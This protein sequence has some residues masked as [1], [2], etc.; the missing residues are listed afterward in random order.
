MG[1]WEGPRESA[2]VIQ[3]RQVLST[4]VGNDKYSVWRVL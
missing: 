2:A 3:M 4:V 1:V